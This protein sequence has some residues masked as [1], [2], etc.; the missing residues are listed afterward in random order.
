MLVENYTF[1]IKSFEVVDIP[2]YFIKKK[3]EPLSFLK[4]K[5]PSV[6]L[7]VCGKKLFI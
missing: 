6:T 5:Y 4:I 2:V 7:G 3:K 1:N